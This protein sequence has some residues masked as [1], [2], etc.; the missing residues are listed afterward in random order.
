[1][2][3]VLDDGG[4]RRGFVGEAV[5]REI[6]G[7]GAVGFGQCR[8]DVAVE[9]G[10]GWEAVEEEEDGV[11]LAC[12]RGVRHSEVCGIAIGD[13]THDETPHEGPTR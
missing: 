4:G 10:A 3:S 7:D 12:F 11:T 5:A 1:M 8:E 6:E 9:V 2:S 13:S